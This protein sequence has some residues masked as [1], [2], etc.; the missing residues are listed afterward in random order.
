MEQEFTS[1]K[2]AIYDLRLK[3]LAALPYKIDPRQV[4]ITKYDS[5]DLTSP[6]KQ[7]GTNPF[8]PEFSHHSTISIRVWSFKDK[9]FVRIRVEALPCYPSYTQNIFKAVC[10]AIND[11][12]EDI[13]I[14]YQ[15]DYYVWLDYFCTDQLNHYE[16]REATMKMAWVYA[17][18][19][20]TIVMLDT[21]LLDGNLNSKSW[22]RRV[23]TMQEEFLS[24]HLV[25][26]DRDGN[27]ETKIEAICDGRIVLPIVKNNNNNC[28]F[29]QNNLLIATDHSFG[30]NSQIRK[31]SFSVFWPK[32]IQRSSFMPCDVVYASQ[33]CSQLINYLDVR[34]D[35]KCLRYICSV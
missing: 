32:V 24:Q 21:T 10:T 20:L 19:S 1:M 3:E 13:K 2:Q 4:I 14:G 35:L 31:Q 25:F 9:D 5:K 23:W 28:Y 11:L 30:N 33:Y 26:F 17:T 18:A 34:Y 15:D 12:P 8:R 27:K 29:D 7:N 22:S 16:I 6:K